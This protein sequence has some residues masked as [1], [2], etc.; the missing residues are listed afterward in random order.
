MREGPAMKR[1]RLGVGMAALAMSAGVLISVTGI[2]RGAIPPPDQ[3]KPVPAKPEQPSDPKK[4]DSDKPAQPQPE[5]GLPGLDDLLGIPSTKKEGNKPTLP[6]WM[7]HARSWIRLLL[8]TPR[9]IRSRR[10]WS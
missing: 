5:P 2:A 3:T 8:W 7:P 10:R 1:R 9:S 4:S 6:P